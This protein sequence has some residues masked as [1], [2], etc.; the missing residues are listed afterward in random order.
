MTPS[1][2]KL[3]S[4]LLTYKSWCLLDRYKY[5]ESYASALF[6]WTSL[7]SFSQAGN[8]T[9]YLGVSGALE[10]RSWVQLNNSDP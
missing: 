7:L 3:Y 9:E 2:K 5:F 1:R 4:N 8:R 10:I 6:F